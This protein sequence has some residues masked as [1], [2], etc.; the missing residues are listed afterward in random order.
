MTHYVSRIISESIPRLVF[1]GLFLSCANDPRQV[2]DFLTEKNLPIAVAKDVNHYYKDSGRLS[3]K[4]STALMKDFSNRQR[5]PYREFPEGVRIVNFEN[6][7][8]D[9]ITVLGD[10][11]LSYIKTHISELK[12]NVVIINHSDASKLKTNQ[13]FW[14]RKNKYFFTEERFVLTKIRDTITGI[15]FESME[16]LRKYIAKNTTGDV[17]MS[18]NE[19]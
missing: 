3:S 16:N 6:N 2:R 4:L 14:D 7:G 10:Y 1:V 8:Q 19:L 5:H 18:E 15:S 11:A 9:S 17:F 13:L 12:E